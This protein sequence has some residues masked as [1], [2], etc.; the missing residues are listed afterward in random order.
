VVGQGC[1]ECGRIV[2]LGHERHD[3]GVR[4][5]R[6]EHGDAVPV[7]QLHDALRALTHALRDLSNPGLLHLAQ[8]GREP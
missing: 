8:C 6:G 4:V 5:A 3:T 7:G 1:S 2:R